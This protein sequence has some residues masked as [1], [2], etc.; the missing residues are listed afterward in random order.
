MS[1]AVGIR[2]LRGDHLHGQIC[3]YLAIH[4]LTNLLSS[5]SSCQLS[6]KACLHT[7]RTAHFHQ[8]A[9]RRTSSYEVS[10]LLWNQ[11]G[12]AACNM[13][14]RQ[15]HCSP[16]HQLSS[17][18]PGFSSA[19]SLRHRAIHAGHFASLDVSLFLAGRPV[20]FLRPVRARCLA[21]I[22]LVRTSKMSRKAGIAV[23]PA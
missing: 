7:N 13:T 12:S 18:L 6:R 10:C 22:L 21:N 1:S 17:A 3:E 9:F 2:L 16:L 5:R 19:N 20:P 14:N 15:F 4:L 23:I 11:S 8:A